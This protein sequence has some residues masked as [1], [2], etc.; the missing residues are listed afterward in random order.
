LFLF[1]LLPVRA[2]AQFARFADW[3]FIDGVVTG[4]P[5]TLAESAAAAFSPVQRRSVAFYALS[6]VMGAAILAA[7]IVWLRS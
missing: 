1:V 4:I 3:F 7:L 5:L 2:G 6:A